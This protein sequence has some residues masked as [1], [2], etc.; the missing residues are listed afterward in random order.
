MRGIKPD[1]GDVILGGALTVAAAMEAGGFKAVEVSEEGLRRGIFF[2]R[3]LADKD[4]PLFDD[5]RRGRS[6][7]W[8]TART[9]A[10]TWRT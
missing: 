5:V 7:T 8:R 4:P 9:D 2:E 1:R 6:R 10:S 3:Y